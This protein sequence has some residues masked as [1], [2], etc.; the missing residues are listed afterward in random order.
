MIET[1]KPILGFEDIYEVSDASRVRS[2]DRQ[3]ENGGYLRKLRGKIL[4]SRRHPHY[5]YH[6][7]KLS[8]QGK[9]HWFLTHRLVAEAFLGPLPDGYHTCHTDGDKDNNALTN[10]RYDTVKGNSRD[11]IIH[12]THLRGDRCYNTKIPDRD[13]QKIKADPRP[14]REVAAIYG[15][16]PR[17]IRKIRQGISRVTK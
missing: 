9:R 14:S 3:V 12:G 16:T 4:K 11:R 17:H 7:T 5:G 15:V 1:W 6:Q 2:L 13:L 8:V 10:L